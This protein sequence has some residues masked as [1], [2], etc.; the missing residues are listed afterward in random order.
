MWCLF[1]LFSVEK[2]CQWGSDSEG[3]VVAPCT[4]LAHRPLPLVR[5]RVRLRLGGPSIAVVAKMNVWFIITLQTAL[6][7]FLQFG[8]KLLPS[9]FLARKLCH[10]GSGLLMLQLDPHDQVARVFVYTVVLSSLAMTWRLLPDVP[11]L[12]FGTA[13]DAG[14]T[15]YLLLVALWF[16]ARQ[17]PRALAPLFFADPAGAVFG[18]LASACGLNAAWHENKTVAGTLAVFAVAFVSLG[19]PGAAAR[20][21]V[22]AACAAAEAFGGRTFDNA[23]IAV[24]ALASWVYW[25][26]WANV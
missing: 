11:I 12:R 4:L 17:P 19:V 25:N 18:K 7:A 9:R 21:G 26:G 15:I 20:A 13:Y 10:A 2:R 23:V 6:L 24:P 22:A 5:V 1:G 3:L 14:I 8:E 16:F